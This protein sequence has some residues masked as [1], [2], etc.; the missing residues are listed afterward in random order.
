[1]KAVPRRRRLNLRILIT[2]AGAIAASLG[3][4]ERTCMIGTG[5]SMLPTLPEFC[6]MLIERIPFDQVRVGERDGDIVATRLNGRDVTHRAIARRSDGSVITRG[7]NNSEAD[8]VAT[9]ERNYVGV[10]VG[11]EKPGTVGE[12]MVPSPCI[13]DHR[14]GEAAGPEGT[15]AGF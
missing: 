5:R 7:D 15:G 14:T 2:C 12:L 9:T 3:A 8:S 4:A 1:M 13:G 10:V 11:F 6:R